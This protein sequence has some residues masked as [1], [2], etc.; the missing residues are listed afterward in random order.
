MKKLIPLI[1]LLQ[2][3]I[4]GYSQLEKETILINASASL[5]LYSSGTSSFYLNPG[6]GIFLTDNVALGASLPF[7][8][9][10]GNVY[11][12]LTPWGRYYLTPQSDK[13]FF[14]YAAFGLT[15]LI[16]SNTFLGGDVITVGAGH[17]W[18]LN[19]SIGFEP[20]LVLGTDF[21]SVNMRMLF[22]FQIYFDRN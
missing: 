15:S 8:I 2:L 10:G 11:I 13:S 19:E 4:V 14:L 21:D 22:G 18:L 5:N 3:S 17:V 7:N 6:G 16:N 20:R 1:L 12:G 9:I